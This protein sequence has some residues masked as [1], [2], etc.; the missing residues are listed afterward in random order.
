MRLSRVWIAAASLSLVALSAG[1]LDL[2]KLGVGLT[3]A[4]PAAKAEPQVAPP[5]PLPRPAPLAAAELNAAIAHTGQALLKTAALHTNVPLQPD[6]RASY[7]LSSTQWTAQGA[8]LTVWGADSV[9]SDAIWLRPMLNQQSF[10]K[11]V[12]NLP[13]R[14]TRLY[15]IDCTAREVYPAPKTRDFEVDYA[16]GHGY[17]NNAIAWGALTVQE[18]HI[19]FSFLAPANEAMI[20]YMRVELDPRSGLDI[21]GCDVH[22]IPT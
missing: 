8:Q 6:P 20:L 9:G 12:I 1:A 15:T 2:S 19:V 10:A 18:G 14:P 17:P 13:A 16:E 22:P 4:R 7:T 21:Y 3:T 11:L 5:K